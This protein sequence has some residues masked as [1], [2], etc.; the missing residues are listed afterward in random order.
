M[1][2]YYNVKMVM[3]SCNVTVNLENNHSTPLLF[4]HNGY[5]MESMSMCNNAHYCAISVSMCDNDLEVI[6]SINYSHYVLAYWYQCWFVIM[7][8]NVLIIICYHCQCAVMGQCY[9]SHWILRTTI[10]YWCH[11]IPPVMRYHCQC[12]VVSQRYYSH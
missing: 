3:T 5:C 8:T 4:C 11:I 9:Y 2:T 7:T 1:H 6:I 12:A 10:W